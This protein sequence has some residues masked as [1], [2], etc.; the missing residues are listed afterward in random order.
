MSERIDCVVIGAGVV[1]LATARALAEAG[2]SVV[3]LERNANIGEEA[4]SRNSEVIHAGIYYP[5][6]SLK[7][8]LAVSGKQLLYDYC[9]TRHIPHRRCGKL[10][11]ATSGEQI[12]RLDAIAAQ[13]RRNGVDDLLKLSEPAVRARE[14]QLR[15]AAA[16]WSP[17]TGIID[18]HA[19]MQALQGDLEACD[20]IVATLT[21]LESIDV[22]AGEIR[23]GIRNEDDTDELVAQTVVNAAGL[24]AVPLARQVRGIEL[25]DLPQRYLAKGNYFS[26][27]GA[28]PFRTLVYPLPVAGGLGVHATLD[29]A[30]RIRFGPDVEWVD[31]IDYSVDPARGAAFAESIRHYWPGIDADRLVPG[32]AGIRPKISGPDQ[33]AADFLID[34][35]ATGPRRQLIHLLGIESPGLTA[36]LAIAREVVARIEAAID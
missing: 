30:G 10:L 9:E 17:S 23:L 22:T 24:D 16:L 19:L 34:V 14:P 32:Y 21:E 4:S 8:R 13:A 5:T 28:V 25:H 31:D 6:G 7:A 3:V 11:V 2:R 27:D 12:G 26:Y 36:S 35:A 1:G 18:S 33:P 29:L 20:G 15:A